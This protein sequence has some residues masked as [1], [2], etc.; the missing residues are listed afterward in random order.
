MEVLEIAASQFGAVQSALKLL[1]LHYWRVVIDSPP[2]NKSR[3]RI[4]ISNVRSTD[5]AICGSE[6]NQI[7]GAIYHATH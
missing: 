2:F 7:L 5:L 3:K 6:L 4:T 1:N